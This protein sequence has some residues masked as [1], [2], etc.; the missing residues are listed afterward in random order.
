MFFKGDQAIRCLADW[1]LHAGPK[2]DRQWKNGRSAM[3]VARAWLAHVSPDLPPEIASALQSHPDFTRIK[4]WTGEPEV[5]L[6]LDMRKGET[7]KRRSIASTPR[8]ATI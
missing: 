3:E 5:R 8:T 1:E 6:P 7:P 4:S 2:H